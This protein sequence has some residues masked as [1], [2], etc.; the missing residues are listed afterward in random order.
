MVSMFTVNLH[1]SSAGSVHLLFSRP[2]LLHCTLSGFV[3]F[4]LLEQL[5][6]MEVQVLLKGTRA[7]AANF[8]FHFCG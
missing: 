5:Y 8:T 1:L 3:L 7:A 2:D 6:H 4:F